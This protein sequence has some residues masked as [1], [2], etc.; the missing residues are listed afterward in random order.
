MP[1]AANHHHSVKPLSYSL[2]LIHF[3]IKESNNLIWSMSLIA[4]REL[5]ETCFVYL[6]FGENAIFYLYYNY[7]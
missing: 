3:C 7:K 4:R 2:S 1:S 6:I 5:G